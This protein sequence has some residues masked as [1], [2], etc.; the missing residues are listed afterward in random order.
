M[1]HWISANNLSLNISK[2][3]CMLFQN[4]QNPILN[5][6]EIT[7]HGNNIEKVDHFKYLGIWKKIQMKNARKLP[8]YL[9]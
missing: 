6:E 1:S 7:I 2:T 9:Q 5:H 4:T 8:S 3:K